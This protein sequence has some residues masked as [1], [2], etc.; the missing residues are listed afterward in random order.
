MSEKKLRVMLAGNELGQLVPSLN[1]ACSQMQYSLDLTTVASFE[2]MLATV[3]VINPDVLFLDLSMISPNVHDAVRIANRAAPHVPLI[4]FAESAEKERAIASMNSGAMD[5][6]LKEDLNLP[7]MSRIL[8]AAMERNTVR[9]LSDLLRDPLTT[10]YTREGFQTLAARAIDSSSA[11]RKTIVL[12]C[13]LFEN[14][15][16]IR[17]QFGIGS[18]DRFLCEIGEMLTS[19]FRD[20]DLVARIGDGQFAV[21]AINASAPSAP[22][23]LQR[24]QMRLALLNQASGYSNPIE[25]RFSVGIWSA[26]DTRSFPEFLDSVESQL[27]QPVYTSGI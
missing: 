10:L 22:L 19:C 17:S 26:S 21:L 12:L 13:A 9:G 5:Y 25:L 16:S 7:A 24:L 20:A 6:L 11:E 15:P 14:L 3:K 1:S 4:V 18:A 2:T 23:L 8:S 27:R